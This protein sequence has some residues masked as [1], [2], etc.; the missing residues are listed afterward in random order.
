MSGRLKFAPLTRNCGSFQ[1]GHI[2][3]ETLKMEVSEYA[4]CSSSD[5][6]SIVP[7]ANL[8]YFHQW[9]SPR[10]PPMEVG[11]WSFWL[12]S[13][14]WWVKSYRK[15]LWT[16]SH[17]GLLIIKYLKTTRRGKGVVCQNTLGY[18]LL[19]HSWPTMCTCYLYI[20]M[21]DILYILICAILYYTSCMPWLLCIYASCWDICYPSSAV[22]ILWMVT[23]TTVTHMFHFFS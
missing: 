14:E 7:D 2:S 3:V 17:F 10:W 15:S 1:L 20:L 8:V 5:G 13:H 6:S 23:R 9:L 19:D 22:T 16:R 12:T 4:L 18:G 11:C 21:C